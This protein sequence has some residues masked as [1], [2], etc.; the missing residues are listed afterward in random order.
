MKYIPF[1]VIL[2][3]LQLDVCLAIYK[4]SGL[5]PA[6]RQAHASTWQTLIKELLT[7]S[8][9]P[10][11]REGWKAAA[12]PLGVSFTISLSSSRFFIVLHYALLLFFKGCLFYSS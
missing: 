6:E 11:R 9:K 5:R 4:S 10:K 8:Q 7:N 12:E 2:T 3:D 1:Y